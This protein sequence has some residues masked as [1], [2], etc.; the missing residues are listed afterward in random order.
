MLV[1]TELHSNRA[2]EERALAAER[3]LSALSHKLTAKGE[4]PSPHPTLRSVLK[5][6]HF[7]LTELPPDDDASDSGSD[8]EVEFAKTEGDADR[9][10]TLLDSVQ[11]GDSSLDQLRKQSKLEDYAES[12]HLPSSLGEDKA[13]TPRDLQR[14]EHSKGPS[15]SSDGVI[16]L[17]LSTDEEGEDVR[18]G[19][20]VAVVNSGPGGGCDIQLTVTSTSTTGMPDRPSDGTWTCPICTLY[21]H[22]SPL[23][24]PSPPPL[25][26]SPT[27]QFP[28]PAVDL[29]QS[30]I[31]LF[32]S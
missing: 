21:A 1:L 32:F 13:S 28:S 19:D 30:I 23:T 15:A 18:P 14:A 25:P 10:K 11:T 3:R 5:D 26:R 31:F 16:D 7:S 9:R 27:N 4:P 2:R 12:F 8:E 6:D 17:S 29:D 24:L 20:A 22:S